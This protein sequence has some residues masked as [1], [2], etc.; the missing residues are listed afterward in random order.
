MTLYGIRDG[1]KRAE[2]LKKILEEMLGIE[3]S[4]VLK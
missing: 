3:I 4:W 2:K 1:N